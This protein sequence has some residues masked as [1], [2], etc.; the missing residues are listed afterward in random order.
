MKGI[1]RIFV[2]LCIALFIVASLIG[3]GGNISSQPEAIYVASQMPDFGKLISA[4]SV[5]GQ[6]GIFFRDYVRLLSSNKE[7]HYVVHIIVY[8]DK[9]GKVKLVYFD[10]QRPPKIITVDKKSG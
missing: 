10:Q 3:C 5:Y 7:S 8:E 6:D 4:D 1:Y 2:G 9:G